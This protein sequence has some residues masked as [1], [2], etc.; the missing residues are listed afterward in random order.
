MPRVR[1][2]EQ[3]Q[4][5]VDA[6]GPDFLESLARGLRVVTAFNAAPRPMTLSEAATRW[7]ALDTSA[8]TAS[9]LR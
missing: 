1:R 3:E 5:S 6:H 8:P 9:Y 7:N 4:Q 2:S